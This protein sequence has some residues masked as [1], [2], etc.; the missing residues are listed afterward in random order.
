MQIDR[1]LF[2]E[3]LALDP[4]RSCELSFCVENT[5]IATDVDNIEQDIDTHLRAKLMS[6]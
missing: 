1:E 2:A 5:I 4:E 3:E 6:E